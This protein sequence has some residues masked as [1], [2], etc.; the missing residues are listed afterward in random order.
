[1]NL[2]CTLK[3]ITKLTI[4]LSAIRNNL[5]FYRSKLNKDTLILAM[6]KAQ[7]YGSGIVEIAQFLET[8]HV[9]YF[10]VAYSDEGVILRQNEITTPIIVM[11]PES[12]AFNDII[13]NEL[14]PSIY[15]L[16][17]LN[18]FVNALIKKGIKSYP[19]HLKLD[20][21]MNRLGFVEDDLNK[22]A[23][24]LTMQPEVFV[25]SVFSH[26]AVADDL[27]EGKFTELQISRFKD[28][29]KQLKT[30]LG[31]SFL[32]HIAN[33]AGTLNYSDSHFDMV[34]LGIG[35][36]GLLNN[37]E[38]D[39]E[40]VLSFETQISQIKRIS[41]GSSVGYGRSFLADTDMKIAIIPVGYADGLRREL[42]QGK[43]GFIINGL[44]APIIGNIC[45][46]MCMVDV[47]NLNCKVGD[48]VQI[49]GKQNSI[50]KMSQSLNT[51]PYEIICLISSRVHRV[52]LGLT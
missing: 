51:I 46:D 2:N 19:I 48:S 18:Q 41:K 13:D 5:N 27:S 16:E 34:R 38:D 24:Q 45:M 25:K 47:S 14:E 22:L 50:F 40:G 39:L 44:P 23:V 6:V 32:E 35:M 28:Y 43:W 9:T 15:S 10:G 30:S 52:Y 17:I 36:Y 33:S 21:G 12:N 49:F 20:T 29:A 26:L 7:S 8:Q 1:M 31:Y 37:Y 42:S 11:N 3:H 4:N